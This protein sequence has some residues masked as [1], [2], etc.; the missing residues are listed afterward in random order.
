MNAEQVDEVVRQVRK[1]LPTTPRVEDITYEVGLDGNGAE[2][3]RIE[4]LLADQ[5]T[6]EPYPWS[7]LKKIDDLFWDEFYKKKLDGWPMVRFVLKS[8]SEEQEEDY[9]DEDLAPEDEGDAEAHEKR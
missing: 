2:V 6:R 9:E 3:A 5:E 4:V 7:E 8:E 1:T